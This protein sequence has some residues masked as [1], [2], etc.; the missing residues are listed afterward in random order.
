[1]DRT[2]VAAWVDAYERAWRATGVA[3]LADLFTPDAVYSQGPYREPVVG[4]DAIGRMWDAERD[5]PDEVFSMSSQIVAVDGSTAV[6]RVEVRYASRTEPEYR[7][8]WIAR[9]ATDGRC[10]HFEEWPFW[11]NRSIVANSGA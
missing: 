6:I 1:V 8:L 2:A 7:D 11:P 4:L 10:E 9:F 5:G 3:A